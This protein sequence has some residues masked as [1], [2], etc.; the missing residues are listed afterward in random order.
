MSHEENVQALVK[1]AIKDCRLRIVD[2]DLIP[3]TVNLPGSS[4]K[5]SHI[6]LRALE[7]AS[8][9]RLKTLDTLHLAHIS[10]LKDE[11]MQIEYLVTNDG[12]ILAR[13]DRVS[14]C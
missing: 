9:L 1:Y 5:I 12:E 2:A 7:L 6:Y 8:E 10:C 11:G 13:G 4:V 14:E 3:V